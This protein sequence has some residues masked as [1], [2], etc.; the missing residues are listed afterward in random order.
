MRIGLNL[1]V[2]DGFIDDAHLP[3]LERLKALGYDGVEIPVFEGGVGHYERLGRRL[4]DL[5]LAATIATIVGE[6]T[7]PISA[8]AEVR[9]KAAER[10]AWA[11]DCAAALGADTI[12]GPF[13]SPLGVF[14]GSGP[15][16]AELQRLADAMRGMA[17]YAAG[18][19]IRLSLEPLNR[20]ECYALNTLAQAADLKRRVAHENFGYVYDTFH[21]NIEERDPVGAYIEHA[22]GVNHIHISE[23]DR[24][25]PG[26][27]HIPWDATFRTIR[28]SGYDGWLT[29]E[30]F[31]RAVPALAAATRVWRDL[32]PDLDTLFSESVAMVRRHWEAA[33]R[34]A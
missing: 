33:G 27:G 30:A 28:A 21:A 24:G 2:V 15:T 29:V 7:N 4:A 10:L 6:D 8:E 19:G 5:G 18:R 20:F 32:F 9:A 12:M 11:V 14:T 23:N 31:G 17:E 34:A 25:I 3:V 16:E 1:L 22:A 26:R 13:H